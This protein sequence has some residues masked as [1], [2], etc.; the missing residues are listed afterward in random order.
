VV[1]PSDEVVVLAP[2]LA[3]LTLPRPA[4]VR[5][6]VIT[7]HIDG[8]YTVKLDGEETDVRRFPGRRKVEAGV[9]PQNLRRSKRNAVGNWVS[10]PVAK[11]DSV[12]KGE[13][14]VVRR[15]G[16]PK[17]A[18]DPIVLP[19]R[20]DKWLYEHDA[21]WG[22][23]LVARIRENSAS[24]RVDFDAAQPFADDRATRALFRY[25]T[26]SRD[27]LAEICAARGLET[28]GSYAALL[29]R[30]DLFNAGPSALQ[31]KLKKRGL[32]HR[33]KLAALVGRVELNE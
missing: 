2:D 10:V 14:V 24:F 27:Q 33:G 12:A 15:K 30:I 16:G 31:K 8:T 7:A 22:L 19:S 1:A 6:T 28:E 26:M 4:Q 5:G 3:P 13:C 25:D 29:Y 23:Y 18:T 20:A 11:Y 21:K 32:D 17:L 9:A